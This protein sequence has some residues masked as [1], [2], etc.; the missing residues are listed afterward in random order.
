[1]VL[2]KLSSRL[3]RRQIH[4]QTFLT[5]LSCWY[6]YMY[7]TN[8]PSI[9]G[10]NF[11]QLWKLDPSRGFVRR[12]RDLGD[13]FDLVGGEGCHYAASLFQPKP[14]LCS[15]YSTD[16]VTGYMWVVDHKRS[17][18]CSTLLVTAKHQLTNY[19]YRD[20]AVLPAIHPDLC[21]AYANTHQFC[22]LSYSYGKPCINV[23]Q[24]I[25]PSLPASV[26]T[27]FLLPPLFA[28][29]QVHQ[30]HTGTR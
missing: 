26:C 18:Q 19:L 5:T 3:T 25:I 2:P 29:L 13:L 7:S 24:L 23:V 10:S 21:S 30:L 20:P 12:V 1:M 22:P 16:M 15:A 6:R 9:I 8:L 11:L 4:L 17:E 28:S 27:L 14:S